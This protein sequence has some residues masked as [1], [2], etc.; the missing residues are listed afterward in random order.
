MKCPWVLGGAARGKNQA[1]MQST[2]EIGF[3]HL[4]TDGDGSFLHVGVLGIRTRVGWNRKPTESTLCSLG[5]KMVRGTAWKS[6]LGPA[7]AT[8]I[9]LQIQLESNLTES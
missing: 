8:N 5:L 9:R 3:N 2:P 7:F 1:K 4:G 6:L